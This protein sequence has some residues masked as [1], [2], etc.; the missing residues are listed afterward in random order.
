MISAKPYLSIIRNYLITSLMF[1]MDFILKTLGNFVYIILIYYLW[2]AIYTDPGRIMHGLSFADAFA[3]LSIS[4]TV[5]ILLHSP[6]DWFL[7]SS[8]IYGRIYMDL[9]LPLDFHMNIVSR[10]L[11]SF[12][13]LFITAGLTSFVFLIAVF[14]ISVPIGPNIALF[15]ISLIFAV[16]V[17]ANIDFITGSLAFSSQS[18]WGIKII[19]DQTILFLS[20][21]IIPIQFFPATA[22]KILMALPFQSMFYTPVNILLGKF[23]GLQAVRMMLVQ[24]FWIIVF[25][26]LGRLF[27][28]KLKKKLIINGG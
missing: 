1:R 10:G 18:I 27:F 21:A 19:K 20:G 8:I 11:A 7:S 16:F 9:V 6:V 26:L 22:Q 4:G 23:S 13:N 5:G 14:R 15:L 28:V 17:S 24:L 12:V 25:F 2:K 3:Y